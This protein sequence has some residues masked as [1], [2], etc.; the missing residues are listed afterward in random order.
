MSV[1]DDQIRERLRSLAAEP[2]RHFQE[3]RLADSFMDLTEAAVLIALRP[4]PNGL[5]VLLTRRSED[6]RQHAGQISFPG[7]RMDPED[8]DLVTTALRE[9]WEEV[10]I[11]PADVTVFGALMRMPLVSGYAV[12]VYVGE[13]PAD[14]PLIM[15][16]G[17]I[18]ELIVAPLVDLSNRRIH[19]V[20]QKVWNKMIFPIHYLD[21]GDH[22]VWGATGFMLH[23]LFKYIGL[24]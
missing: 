3:A 22:L 16:P 1:S 6:L 19:R 5:E 17:E 4:G 13:F 18:D 8:N 7:G 10:G 15:N 14:T 21:Y 24:R 20:E 11:P 2:R 12:T 23:E 9:T